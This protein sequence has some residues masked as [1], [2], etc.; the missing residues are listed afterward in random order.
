MPSAS[1]IVSVADPEAVAEFYRNEVPMPLR[2]RDEG[3]LIQS[4]AFLNNGTV[5]LN[6]SI[7]AFSLESLSSIV[8]GKIMGYFG[9]DPN[10]PID[11]KTQ[12]FT[13][14]INGF[15]AV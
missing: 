3:A 14:A 12:E 10:I 6:P 1:Y 13:A 5:T 9:P 7:S 8:F 15:F 2:R 4:E 11:N